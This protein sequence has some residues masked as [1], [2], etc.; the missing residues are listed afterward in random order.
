M[1]GDNARVIDVETEDF[2]H[3]LRHIAVACTVESIA[4][5]V[6]FL[7]KFVGNGIEIGIVGH[8]TMERIIKDTDLRSGR[9]QRVNSTDSLQMASI[10][11]GCKVTKLLNI[12]LNLLVNNDALIIFIPS[13]HDAMS[14]GINLFQV[15]NGTEFGVE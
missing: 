3:A 15:F 7:V 12:L 10:M 6:V 9:H 2:A 14:H 8:G 13:L 11:N 1:T 4:T 5:N